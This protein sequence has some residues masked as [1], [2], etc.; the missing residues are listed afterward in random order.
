LFDRV[1]PDA[2]C[3]TVPVKSEKLSTAL[4]EIRG[5]GKLSEFSDEELLTNDLIYAWRKR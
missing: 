3:Q 1:F 2:V 4:R 5:E